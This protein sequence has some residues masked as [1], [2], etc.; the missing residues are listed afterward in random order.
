MNVTQIGILDFCIKIN[1]KYRINSLNF[2]RSKN[3]CVSYLHSRNRQ[4]KEPVQ[5]LFPP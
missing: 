3:K 1:I 2:I 4:K 5:H